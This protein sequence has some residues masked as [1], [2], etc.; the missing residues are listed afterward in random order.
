MSGSTVTPLPVIVGDAG[1]ERRMGLVALSAPLSP[2][3]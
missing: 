2:T 1:A 3:A